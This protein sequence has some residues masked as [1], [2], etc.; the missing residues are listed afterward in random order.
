MKVYFIRCIPKL[1][2]AQLLTLVNQRTLTE[3]N[4]IFEFQSF[5]LTSIK[6]NV[7]YCNVV[8][9]WEAR[10]RVGNARPR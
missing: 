5:K 4:L 6:L 9:P 8:K 1:S 10:P 3:V 7:T 2:T